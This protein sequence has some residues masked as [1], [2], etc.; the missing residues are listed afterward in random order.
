[1]RNDFS[2]G[3]GCEFGAALLELD[4]Q[5]AKILDDAVV[6]DGNIVG[7]MRM[8]VALSRLAMRGPAGMADTDIA[9]ERIGAQTRL[10]VFQFAFGATA[11][12]AIAFQR[13][14][15][16]GIVTAIFQALERIDQLLGNRPA[17][18]NADDPAHAD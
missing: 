12:Q 2:V 10:E 5:L 4:A 7:R 6:D 11:L 3:L 9:R 16:G 15:A 13:R 1:M 17:S 18:Q 8:R 14:D